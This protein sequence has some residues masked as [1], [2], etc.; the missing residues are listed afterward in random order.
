M[1]KNT[2]NAFLWFCIG[3][4]RHGFFL[5]ESCGYLAFRYLCLRSGT[6]CFYTM[7]FVSHR[8]QSLFNEKTIKLLAFISFQ[9]QNVILAKKCL[10][11]TALLVEEGY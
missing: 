1:L 4:R 6:F 7:L 10:L 2:P 11:E 8:L 9:T 5:P 3:A